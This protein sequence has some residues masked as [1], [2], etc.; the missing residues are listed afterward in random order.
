MKYFAKINKDLA[1]DDKDG[2]TYGQ[3]FILE[4]DNSVSAA[5]ASVKE[6]AVQLSRQETQRHTLL[7]LLQI[8]ACGHDVA[9]AAE[10]V[11]RYC[12]YSSTSTTPAVLSLALDVLKASPAHTYWVD[13]LAVV[14]DCIRSGSSDVCTVALTKIP[15]M[16]HAALQHLALFATSA[17]CDAVLKDESPDVRC[18]AVGAAAAIALRDRPLSAP[19]LDTVRLEQL[20][21]EHS[22]IVRRSVARC[23][24]A[25]LDASFDSAD[26]VAVAA[27][28][29]LVSFAARADAE[30]RKSVLSAT[31]DATAD[32]VWMLFQGRLAQVSKRFEPIALAPRGR[33]RRTTVKALAQL[34]AR[35]LAGG[36][37]HETGGN[38]RYLI[39][40]RG[41]GSKVRE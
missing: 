15:G 14:I 36:L 23:L 4:R 1:H 21:P 12:L 19:S 18:A 38:G 7:R 33:L 35:C 41:M 17:V 13:A 40:C 16:P 31:R 25:L 8:S 3:N 6:L 10:Q 24:H 22:S 9:V 37:G 39:C 11:V 20:P 34:A 30:R 27:F 28:S 2:I 5:M 26:E 29:C 32:S